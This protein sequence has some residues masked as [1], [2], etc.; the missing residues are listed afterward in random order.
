MFY[1][2]LASS[3]S[4]ESRYCV[5]G[6]LADD[7]SKTALDDLLA[8]IDTYVEGLGDDGSFTETKEDVVIEDEFVDGG[9]YKVKQI[10]ILDR[11]NAKKLPVTTEK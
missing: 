3:G 10:L 5:F 4:A 6:E 2:F 7:E 11:L 8:A 1:I 9:S